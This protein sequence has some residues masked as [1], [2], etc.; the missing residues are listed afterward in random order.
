MVKFLTVDWVQKHILSRLS[1]KDKAA[2]EK[3][4]EDLLGSKS[5]CDSDRIFRLDI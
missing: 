5:V 4:I 1:K 2:V 3:E